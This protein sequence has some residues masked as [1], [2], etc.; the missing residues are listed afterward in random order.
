[1]KFKQVPMTRG[2][3]R[4]RVSEFKHLAF[5][6]TT[7]EHEALKTY[8]DE[9]NCSMSAAIAMLVNKGLEVEGNN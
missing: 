6:A 3:Y 4:K 7:T 8:A 1:M 9:H 5:Y 2:I